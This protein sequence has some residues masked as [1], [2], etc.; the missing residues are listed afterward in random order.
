MHKIRKSWLVFV[1]A[2]LFIV[3]TAIFVNKN[4]GDKKETSKVLYGIES[5]NEIKKKHKD[6]YLVIYPK[7]SRY[8]QDITVVREISPQGKQIAKYDI[9]DNNFN[10]A[11]FFQKP[12]N[13]NL[14]YVS[15]F[16][17]PVLDN[18]YYTYDIRNR[19]FA[20]VDIPYFNLDV[21]VNHIMHYGENVVFNT[22]ASHITGDQRYDEEEESFITSISNYD[23][24]YSIETEYNH[25]PTWSSL[26]NID[27][28]IIFTVLSSKS[29]E[30]VKSYVAI[31]DEEKSKISYMN[32]GNLNERMYTAYLSNKQTYIIGEFGNLYVLN[33]DLTYKSFRIFDNY[34]GSNFESY[35]T[36][37]DSDSSLMLDEKTAFHEIYN[38]DLKKYILGFIHL[39]KENP[40]FEPFE[41]NFLDSNSPHE[42][43]YCD[44]Y[45]NRLYIHERTEKS[46]N[47]YIVV[48]DSKTFELID[49]FPVK[50]DSFVD[51]VVY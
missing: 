49:K 30:E 31:V 39:D 3:I 44:E 47:G 51:M 18:F 15:F 36:Y 42:L 37:Y 43:L 7:D 2:F 34:T 1:F 48:I 38:F 40:T 22:I 4:S 35:Y 45:N 9:V 28:K 17:E 19:K 26:I 12:N 29:Y 5:F 11:I 14:L 33:E 10:R 16:G 20:K 8:S 21:G 32:F 6:S 50:Y 25:V 41:P 24:K 27:N 46:E 23:K 13:K